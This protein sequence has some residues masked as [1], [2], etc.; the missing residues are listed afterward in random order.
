MDPSMT[1]T[2]VNK[3][4][5]MTF[6][7]AIKKVIEGKRIARIAWSPDPDYGLLRDSWLTIFIK[8]EFHVWK[9]NDGDLMADDWIVL[10]EIN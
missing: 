9:V 6:P 5:T 2:V 7:E 10:P 8:G 1:P 4:E 3:S